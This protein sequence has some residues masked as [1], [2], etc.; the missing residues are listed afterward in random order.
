MENIFILL[1]M[2]NIF[3]LLFCVVVLFLIFIAQKVNFTIRARKRVPYVIIPFYRNRVNLLPL[4]TPS[5]NILHNLH[6][7]PSTNNKRAESL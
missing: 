6:P 7:P 5:E 4:V 3:I 2:E 1:K